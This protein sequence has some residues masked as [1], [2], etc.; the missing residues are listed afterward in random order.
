MR[1]DWIRY[2][3]AGARRKL[4]LALI[5]SIVPSFASAEAPEV[6]M[7]GDSLTQGYGLADGEGLVPQLQAWLDAQ[8]TPATLINMGVSGDTSAG[9]AARVA[10]SL[11]EQS[12]ALV[13]ALGGNDLLRGLPPKETRKNLTLILET[14]KGRGLPVL[15]IGLPA[16]AN[17]GPDWQAEFNALY[18]DLA[19]TYGA[20]YEP[21]L[22]APL[23]AL[24][25]EGRISL[26]QNDNI[27]PSKEG[28]AR[29]VAHIGPKVQALVKGLDGGSAAR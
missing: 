20:A 4:V 24:P 12:R 8:G 26:M 19:Q 15:L 1:G 16:P 7:L 23:S 25:P 27:H 22:L 17:Y 5:L 29:V 28:V 3:A 6:V 13:V 2:G 11:T 9:G 14:A 18:A 10:W 21:D